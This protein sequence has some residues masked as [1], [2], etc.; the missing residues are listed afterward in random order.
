MEIWKAIDGFENYEISNYGRVKSNECTIV[1]SN[2][3]ITKYK[4]KYLKLES[5]RC[6]GKG[7]YKRVTLCKNNKPKR[8][9]VHRLVAQYFIDNPHNKKCV[10]HIDGNPS[11]NNI[12]NLEWCTHSE[13]ERH[14]YDIL[15]KINANRKLSNEAIEDI[16]KNCIKGVNK[17][18]KGNVEEF[19]IRYNVS[20]GTILNVINKKYYVGIKKLSS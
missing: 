4:E 20:Q 15:G 6:N 12:K 17:V 10:N 9:Q 14:S 2:G 19:M 16:L 1:Y 5:N 8:F 3:M 18:N 13:N 7:S 11:N